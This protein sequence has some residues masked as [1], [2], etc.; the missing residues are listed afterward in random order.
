MH[1]RKL[2]V[3]NFRNFENCEIELSNKNLIFGMNDV[4]K[5]NLMYALRML[6]DPSIRNI[7]LQKT[8]FNKKNIEKDIEISCLFDLSESS[9]YSNFL[10]AEIESAA[11][12]DSEL[13]KISLIANY[14]NGYPIVNLK[15][16][17]DCKEP[18]I[19]IP[20]RGINRSLLDNI[21]YCVFIPSQNNIDSSFK[22]Y[23]KELLS[24]HNSEDSDGDILEQ[25]ATENTAINTNISKLSSVKKMEDE[26]NKILSYFDNDYQIKISSNHQFG[27]IYSKLELFMHDNNSQDIYPTA[28]DG[29]IRKVMYSLISYLLKNSQSSN[30]KI[31]ILL[32][33][34]PENHLF[35][36]AQISLSRA[37]FNET[38]AP[39]IFLTTHSP[40]LFFRIC[41]NANLIRIHK[42]NNFITTNSQC[43]IVPSSY[44]NYK[45]ILLENL[46]QCLFADKVLLVEGE[47][48]KL[49]FE[50]ILDTLEKD[51]SKIIIQPILGVNFEKYVEILKSLDIKVYIRTDND[52]KSNNNKTYSAIGYNRCIKLFNILSNNCEKNKIPSA[53]KEP[54]EFREYINTDFSND[55]KIFN[56][57]KIY[58]SN[59]DLENDLSVALEVEDKDKFVRWLQHKKWQNMWY[60]ITFKDENEELTPDNILSKIFNNMSYIDCANKIYNHK[61]FS[62]LKDLIEDK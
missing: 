31:P 56:Q 21:F 37:I 17:S 60:F 47:S 30:R 7:P 43:A 2:I 34:E 46:S 42:D 27:D 55:I 39:F 61:F 54:N 12:N 33:E 59:I 10:I 11:I 15:W 23:K 48:E 13:F 49:L 32:I 25:I 36:S 5:S 19:D 28:G 18:L 44:H 6:F 4:G 45:N 40:Q 26:V 9:D 24:I 1:L 3:K 22:S 14:N 29:R 57:H 62:C 50:W 35:I 8:D 58:L 41:N 52:I 20:M 51:R 53:E 38:F 16:G